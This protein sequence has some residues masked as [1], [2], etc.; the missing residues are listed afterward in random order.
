MGDCF[1]KK[2]SPTLLDMPLNV[3][4]LIFKN[5]ELNDLLRSRKVCR[6]L[7]TAVDEFGIRFDGVAFAMNDNCI[8]MEFDENVL[9]YTDEPNGG[10][11]VTWYHC[12]EGQPR[13]FK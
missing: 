12:D 1:S 4:N 11:T 8:R 6:G 7:R 5:L 9:V 13:R 2:V 3:A 10:T